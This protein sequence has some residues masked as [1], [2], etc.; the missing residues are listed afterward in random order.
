MTQ[1]VTD[2]ETTPPSATFSSSA[3]SSSPLS[4]EL[5]KLTGDDNDLDLLQQY[6]VQALIPLKEDLADWLNTVLGKLVCS[7]YKIF[8]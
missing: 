5:L 2:V 4:N 1:T 7:R 8:L 6:K 3:S